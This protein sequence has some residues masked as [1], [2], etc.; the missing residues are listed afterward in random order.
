MTAGPRVAV[1]RLTLTRFRSYESLRLEVPPRSVVVTGPNGAGKTNLLEAISLLA[2]GRGL[3]GTRL[4]ELERRGPPSVPDRDDPT[5]WAVAAELATASGVREVATGTA[6]SGGERRQV[7]IDGRA[8]RPAALAAAV[9]LCWLT[10]AMD[11]LFI[12]G[13]S[14]RRR[15]L[16]R[17]VFGFDP[18]H[19]TRVGRYEQALRERTRLLRDGRGDD[20]WLSGLETILATTGVAIAAARRDLVER[21]SAAWAA[22]AGAFPVGELAVTGTVEDRL[23]GHAALEVEDELRR[24][25]AAGRAREAA[26]APA[27]GPH[28]SDLEVRFRSAHRVMPAAMCSTGEQKALLIGLV[29]ANAALLADDR[30]AAPVLLLDEVAAHLDP[31]RRAALYARLAALGGQA[32]L[33]GTDP[34]LFRAIGD[35]ATHLTLVAGRLA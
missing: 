25:L 34:E 9:T 24:A 12:E 31:T 27:P 20:A 26:G 29:L 19:A 30:G 16:D 18:E 23:P 17:C 13:A 14:G 7:R 10:P 5:G 15:F 28:R 2:P 21:L 4:A 8:V 33:T 3:R 35:D 22:A 1:T 32:W 11:R 6:D